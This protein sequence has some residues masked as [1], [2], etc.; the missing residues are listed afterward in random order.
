MII[1]FPN[2]HFY[3]EGVPRA[4]RI[5]NMEFTMYGAMIALGLLV[6]LLTIWIHAGRQGKNVNRILGA[7][8]AAFIG[9]T[10]GGRALYIFCNYSSYDGDLVK[11]LSL[12][13]GGMSVFGTIIGAVILVHLYCLLTRGSFLETADVLVTGA[14]VA[15]AIGRWGDYFNR[16]SF[17]E[18]TDWFWAMQIPIADVRS[19]EVTSLMRENLVDAG[20]ISFIQVTPVFFIESVLCLILFFWLLTGSR[21]RK[22]D[23]QLYFRYMTAYGVI[24]FACEWLRT[25]RLLIPGTKIGLSLVLSLA[26]IVFFGL[27]GLVR[28]SLARKREEIR[29]EGEERF[30]QDSGMQERIEQRRENSRQDYS[31]EELESEK[32]AI[33]ERIRAEREEAYRQELEEKMNILHQ[34]EFQKAENLAEEPPTKT[35]D[36]SVS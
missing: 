21:H 1:R 15:Q 18:Y 29:R 16:S 11:M 36:G 33:K 19:E 14:A 6:G 22:Y 3:I 12:R 13:E 24:R 35:G 28:S 27:Q 30:Y 34:K 9:G 10:A 7:V 8:I 5:L 32:A 26:F 20:G 23:G 4:F 2:L 17:G 25:D 31:E